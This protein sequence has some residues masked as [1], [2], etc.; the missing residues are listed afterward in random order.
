MSSPQQRD[1]CSSKCL[2]TGQDGA[3]LESQIE[4]QYIFCSPIP[5]SDVWGL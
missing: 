3:H 5:W 1:T 4:P 2:D